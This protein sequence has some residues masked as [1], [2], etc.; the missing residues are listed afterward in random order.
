MS[1]FFTEVIMKSPLLHTTN[2]VNDLNMLAPTFRTKVE[3][4]LAES[5]KNNMP[6][7]VL[8]TFR[9]RERQLQLYEAKATKLK[10]VGVHFYG[11]AADIVKCVNGEP[12]FKGDFSFLGKLAK[13]HGLI[14]GGDWGEPDKPH[15]FRDMDHVQ[16]ISVADQHKLFAGTWYPS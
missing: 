3:A 4:L 10:T 5:E 11:L 2:R 7:M 13:E 15:S 9:S 6:L 14:W 12:S 16:L 1:N 8:E